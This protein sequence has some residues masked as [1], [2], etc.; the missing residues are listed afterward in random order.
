MTAIKE[1][2]EFTLELSGEKTNFWLYDRG[3]P[4][5]NEAALREALPAWYASIK[6]G[7]KE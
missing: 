4:Q 1:N 5:Q 6:P 2:G 7:V 3:D